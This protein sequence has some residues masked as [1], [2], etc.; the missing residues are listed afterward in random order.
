MSFR[1]PL[2][3]GVALA[4]GAAT[5]VA[6]AQASIIDRPHFKVLGVVIVWAADDANGNTP[7][8]TDF[9]IND[10]TGAGDTDL[11]GGTTVD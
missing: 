3:A 6:P 10:T 1:K 2:L 11:I 9:I 5:L 7:I 8:A 4:M